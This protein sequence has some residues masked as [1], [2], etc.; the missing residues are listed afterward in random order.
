MQNTRPVLKIVVREADKLSV[1]VPLILLS[2]IQG[3]LTG[4]FGAPGI[5][6]TMIASR[7]MGPRKALILSTISQFVGPFLFGVAA[8]KVLGSEVIASQDITP[9]V[10]YIGLSATIFWMIVTFYLRIPCSSTHALLG[11]LIGVTLAASGPQAIYSDGLLKVLASLLLSAPLG[12][13]GGFLMIR[14]WYWLAKNA[15][16][17]INERFNQGQWVASFGLGMALGS[18]NAQSTMGV[19]AMGLVLAGAAPDFQVP[20][21][22]IALCAISLAFGNLIG[23][24]RLVK[25]IGGKFFQIRPIHGFSAEL[26][27]AVI[28]G[29]ASVIG[30]NVSTTHVTSSSIV[31]AGAGERLSMVRWGF[32]QNVFVT[33]VITIPVTATLAG[34]AYLSLIHLGVK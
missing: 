9:V 8:A 18:N 15:T 34:L 30:G 27:S 28:I 14:L 7:A 3:L 16:P 4:L 17:H 6:A 19:M 26:A 32:V 2:S 1:L 13:I 29:I 11:G 20:L 24:M 23:G 12:F 10:L 31:G 33:W 5:V 22:V 25:S 21:W